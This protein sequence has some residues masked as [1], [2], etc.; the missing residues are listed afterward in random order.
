MKKKKESEN[1]TDKADKKIMTIPEW[2]VKTPGVLEKFNQYKKNKEGQ[3]PFFCY[4]NLDIEIQK[5]KM[6]IFININS[7]LGFL[8]SVR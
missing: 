2:I 6:L 8:D 3:S 7:V 4:Y 5:S 1:I